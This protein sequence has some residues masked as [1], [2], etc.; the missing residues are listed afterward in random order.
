MS[1]AELAE[2]MLLRDGFNHPEIRSFGLPGVSVG[3]A[4]WG[5]RAYLPTAP[6]RALTEAELV[7]FE[8]L[9]Q[10]LWC[11]G[12]HVLQ[13]PQGGRTSGVDPQ[14]GERFL[15]VCQSRLMVGGAREAMQHRVMRDAVLTASRLL[16][17]LARA[18]D[19]LN[20]EQAAA[21]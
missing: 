13:Q 4:S 16:V 21:S 10:A 1:G 11:Y 7:Q 9:V 20:H 19:L 6:R 17:L 8:L 5:G 18:A 12:N 15:R 2:D 3:C 14:Y